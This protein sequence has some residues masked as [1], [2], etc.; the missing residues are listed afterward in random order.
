ME[1]L[2]S[3]KYPILQFRSKSVIAYDEYLYPYSGSRL[4]ALSRHLSEVRKNT[5]AYSGTMTPG[6]KKRLTKAI[7]LLI[8]STKTREIYNPVSKTNHEFKLSF[9]TL[10]IPEMNVKPDAKFCNKFLLEPFIR[11]LRRRYGLKNYVW[12]L[13]LQANGMVHYHIT[14]N[15]FIVHTDLKDE[16]NNILRRNDMLIDYKKRTGKND[17]NSTDI[18]SVKNVKNLEAYLIKYV[19]KETQNAKG[20]K[21][22]IWDCS[23]SLKKSEYFS[24]ESNWTYADRLKSLEKKG[25]VSSFAGDRYVIFRFKE[26]P[27]YVLLHGEER[28]DYFI[29][30]NYI[31]NGKEKSITSTVANVQHSELGDFG[32]SVSKAKKDFQ[33]RLFSDRFNARILQAGV[34]KGEASVQVSVDKALFNSDKFNS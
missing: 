17:P 29:H 5:P 30:L 8:Q 32:K 12:K 18:H 22:K 25:Q 15:V 7:S 13:E 23:L 20:V 33:F 14:S 3:L 21:T 9:L 16:W 11:V 26:N 6:A 31:R 2:R 28:R 19:T 1:S 4:S 24:I 34:C 27:V 10:T